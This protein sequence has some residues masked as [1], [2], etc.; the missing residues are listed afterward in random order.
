MP[1][2]E[3]LMIDFGRVVKLSLSVAAL[4]CPMAAPVVSQVVTG[5]YTASQCPSCA[6]WNAPHRSVP[7]F[8]NTYWV[9]TRGLGAILITSDSGHVLIDGG[10]PESAP[11]IE[12]NVRDLGFRP[13]DIRVILNS[14]AHFDHAGG[15]AA[16]QRVSGASVLASPASADALRTGLPTA[17]D[18]QRGVALA[19]PPVR[20]VGVI[21]DGDT[22]RV[23]SLT[24]VAH[25][26]PGHS[27]GGTTWSWRSC[28]ETRCAD[29]VYADSQTPV[30]DG[31]FRFSDGDRARAFQAGLDVIAALPCDVLL[32]PHPGGSDLW[33]RLE[34]RENGDPDALFDSQA[35]KRYAE[36]GQARLAARLARERSG[37][38][39][40]RKKEGM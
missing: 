3:L 37:G 6:A 18:P 7:L 8:G 29:L 40:D 15:I 26:T 39:E 32:T 1:T 9:G 23:G 16:L 25:S 27:P 20:E 19:F 34:I 38:S 33:A 5:G 28:D 24:V 12:T 14:H 21:D 35:C 13:E 36:A 17:E 2:T 11:L 10:L 30:S 4:S 22:V 31:G